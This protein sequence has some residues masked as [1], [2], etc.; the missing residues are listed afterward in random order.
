MEGAQ[1]QLVLERLARRDVAV[2]HDHAADRRVVDQVPDDRVDRA[3]RA[4]R[5]PG[6]ELHRGLGIGPP[7]HGQEQAPQ[8]QPIL[9]MDDVERRL[10]DTLLGPVAQDTLHRGRFVGD[11]AIATEDHVH[12]RGVADERAEALLAPAQ[13]RRQQLFGH[14]LLAKPAVLVREQPRSPREGNVDERQQR[15]RH[16]ADEQDDVATR[17]IDGRVDRCRVLVHLVRAHDLATR[18]PDRC[19]DGQESRGESV[20]ELVLVRAAG[21]ELARRG[22]LEDLPQVIGN[23]EVPAAQRRQV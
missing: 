21:A 1:P 6:T 2:V 20:L 23:A 9:G 5:V 15:G 10:A 3:P 8:P 12:V 14:R 17:S 11:L 4:V 18:R 16:A 7:G 19:V 22:A 13:I